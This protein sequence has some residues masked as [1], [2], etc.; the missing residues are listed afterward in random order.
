MISVA[1]ISLVVLGT[2]IGSFGALFL[3]I[4][5]SD[6]GFDLKK[7]MRNKYLVFGVILYA[8]STVPFIMALKM[9]EL[10]VLYP[11]VSITYIWVIILSLRFLKERMNLYKWMGI[12]TIILGVVLIGLAK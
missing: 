4:G 1:A 12:I 8:V 5:S 10:S 2:L 6:F 9:E 3:K 11:V 7:I